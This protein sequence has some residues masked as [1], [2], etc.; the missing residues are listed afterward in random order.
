[1]VQELGQT[2]R[3]QAIHPVW[4]FMLWLIA[5]LGSTLADPDPDITEYFETLP[6]RT[7]HCSPSQTE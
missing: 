4:L 1:M 3:S 5:L 2:P 6:A 7:P